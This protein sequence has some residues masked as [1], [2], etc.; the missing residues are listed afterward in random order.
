M[1][2]QRLPTADE[3]VCCITAVFTPPGFGCKGSTQSRQ[4]FLHHPLGFLQARFLTLRA[5]MARPDSLDHRR[6]KL[7]AERFGTEH[8]VAVNLLIIGC[9]LLRQRQRPA[10]EYPRWTD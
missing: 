9:R 2:G 8:P 6:Q 1:I 10:G 3:P 5:V 7:L 4:F